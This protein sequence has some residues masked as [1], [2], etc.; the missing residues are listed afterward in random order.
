MTKKFYGKIREERYL[1]TE[2]VSIKTVKV[3][4][5]AKKNDSML[6]ICCSAGANLRYL[7]TLDQIAKGE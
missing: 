1:G 7:K 4:K 6:E 5:Y 2:V 3:V